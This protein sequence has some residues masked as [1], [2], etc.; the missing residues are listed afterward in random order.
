MREIFKSFLYQIWPF[1]YPVIKGNKWVERI[2]SKIYMGKLK[3][4]NP[5]HWRVE[6]ARQM[7]AKI[8]ENCRFYSLNMFS[9]PYLI[10]I[11]D[12]VIVSG[13]VIFI[14]HD[15]GVYLFMNEEPELFG[16]FGRIKVGNNCFIGMGAIILPDVEIGNN[17]IIGAGA[18]VIDSI[19]DNSV[20]LGN[21]AKV[22]FKTDMYRRM[23]LSNKSTLR[24]SRYA[25]PRHDKMPPE[26]K[27]ALLIKT[28]G[29]TPI[30]KPKM[31]T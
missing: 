11:G 23:R 14:T 24:D 15:G 2:N 29:N 4:M 26:E 9:E 28:V 12:N 8:G 17:C 18:V 6:M 27:K 10:E 31:R 25:F 19:P 21:P 20:A 16:H 3:N 5:V 7:G 13:E 1:L 30:R 22:I